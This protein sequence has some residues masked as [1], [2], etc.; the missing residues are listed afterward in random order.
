MSDGCDGEA[1]GELSTER[2]GSACASMRSYHM[3]NKEM[4]RIDA[5]NIQKYS[6]ISH[7]R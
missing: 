3:Q 7:T 2:G 5:G 1:R 6:A 4:S